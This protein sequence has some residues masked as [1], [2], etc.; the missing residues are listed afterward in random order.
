MQ[1]Y[2][3]TVPQSLKKLQEWFASI[4][5]RPIDDHSQMMPTSPSNIPME[6]EARQYI[7][8]SPTLKPD[9]RIQLYNQQYWW[10]LLS[11]L[12]DNFPSATRLLGYHTF[13]HK[14]AIPFLQKYP[15]NHWSLNHL[16]K[17]LPEWVRK[18]YKGEIPLLIQDSI[19]ADWSYVKSFFAGNLPFP[20]GSEEETLNKKLTLQPHV[21][22]HQ[23]SHPFMAFRDE[24]VDQSPEYWQENPLPDM[25]S[26][27]KYFFVIYRSSQYN[28]VWF[29][30]DYPQ[31]AILSTFK[32]GRSIAEICDW[33]ENQ[34]QEIQ[35]AAK[36]KLHLF[37][38]EWTARQ[39]L[40]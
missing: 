15:P 7:V 39:L 31:Y 18:N 36:D 17:E 19:D 23:F 26:K 22:L 10:R 40:A 6:I 12:H 37:F 35:E 27:G 30:I 21:N 3:P 13:N 20:L 14:I 4:I 5:V 25:G 24:V 32:E 33:L 8:P 9:Q 11:T 2:D 1:N 34:E 16:G 38:Q 28:I 29:E